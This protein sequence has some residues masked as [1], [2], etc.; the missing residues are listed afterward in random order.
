[1]CQAIGSIYSSP[2]EN[3]DRSDHDDF[4][5]GITLRKMLFLIHI[6]VKINIYCV[7]DKIV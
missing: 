6:L 7:A 1:M 3:E 4:L 2:K 5:E